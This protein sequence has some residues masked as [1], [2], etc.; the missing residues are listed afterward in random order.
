MTVFR[1]NK[2]KEYTVM[3]NIHLRDKIL[4]LKA[5]CLLS[6]MFSLA[7]NWGYS[8]MDIEKL[9]MKSCISY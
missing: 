6:F 2:N 9:L 4:F 1:I 5:K 3:S 7:D 8:L